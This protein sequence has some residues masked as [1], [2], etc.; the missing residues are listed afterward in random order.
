MNKIITWL[1]V[2]IFFIS[3]SAVLATSMMPISASGSPISETTQDE[4]AGKAIFDKLLAK[5]TQCPQLTDDDFDV[6]GDYFM[7]QMMG[8]SHAS[9]NTRMEQALGADGE[10]QMHIVMG[11]RLS[12][13]DPTV[14][15]PAGGNSFM[16]GMMGGSQNMMGWGL[17][18]GMPFGG[19]WMGGSFMILQWGL[20]IIAIVMIM[21]SF[22]REGG[23]QISGNSALEILKVRYAKG[24]ITKQ[25]FEDKQKDVL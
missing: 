3:P 24:E 7:G 2:G 17:G 1:T 21:K 6:L 5:Q 22:T 11:K 19:G 15:Y 12:G 4:L 10:K 20:I 18:Y 16:A 13:C 25:E 8:S 23:K 9:M 14:A